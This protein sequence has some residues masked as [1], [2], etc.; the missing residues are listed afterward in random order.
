MDKNRGI[1]LINSNHGASN[2]INGNLSDLQYDNINTVGVNMLGLSSYVFV[3]HIPNVNE[4]NKVGVIDNGAQSFPVQIPE[5]N[6]NNVQ[7]ATAVSN[8]LSLLPIGAVSVTWDGLKFTINTGTAI[9]ILT[10]PINGGRRDIFDMMGMNKDGQLLTI[11]ETVKLANLNYSECIYVLSRRLMRSRKDTDHNSNFATN[12]IGVIYRESQD[13]EKGN[14]RHEERIY[15][16][17]WIK[18]RELDALDGFDIVLVDDEGYQIPSNK[19]E[20]RLEFYTC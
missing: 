3:D 15:N 11:N 9:K 7:L 14:N 13:P 17:K 1:I 20:Y 2:L 10:N 16:I 6:Y 5:G 19:Y 4:Y 12:N 18:S 8:A